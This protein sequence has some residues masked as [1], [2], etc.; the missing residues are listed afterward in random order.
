M[1]DNRGVAPLDP[2]SDVGRVRI[3]LGD[4]VYQ[5]Y[6]P[7]EPGYGKYSDYSDEELLSYLEQGGSVEEAMYRIYLQMAA[8]AAREAK[9]IQDFDLKINTEKRAE[10]LLKLA[11]EWR[12]AASQA[13]AD[14]FEVFD[15]GS[16]CGCVPELAQWPVCRK[17]CS[18]GGI[19]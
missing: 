12:A 5:P 19:F 6:D 4:V 10:A 14:I 13:A 1:N 17:G 11:Q 15:L 8:S 2:S 18:S 3:Q 9:Q 16:G 7:P